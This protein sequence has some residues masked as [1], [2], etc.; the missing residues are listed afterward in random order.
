MYL[1]NNE[2][3]EAFC[4]V[5]DVFSEDEVTK[6]LAFR[7]T[8]DAQP[9]YVGGVD[10]VGEIRESSIRWLDPT[11][12]NHWIFQ[13]IT[14][15]V[16]QVNDQYFKM[17]LRGFPSLQL[18]EYDGDKKGHYGVHADCGY[19]ISPMRWR[20][21]SLTVQLSKPEEYEGGDLVLYPEG[22]ECKRVIEKQLGTMCLFRSHVLHEV[23][24]ITKGNRHSLVTWVEGPLW[25]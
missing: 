21:L 8:V 2:Q 5:P 25:R 19:G 9:G 13:R 4:T 3:F 16:N 23:T 7:E 12:E 14:E 15:V 18:T 17:E 1:L 10:Q 20:K 11:E 22:F 24:P 6:I